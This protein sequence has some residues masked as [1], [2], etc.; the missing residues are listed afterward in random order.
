MQNNETQIAVLGGGSWGTALVKLLQYNNIKTGWWIRRPEQQH[1]ILTQHHNPD[2]LSHTE[3]SPELLFTTTDLNEL[4]WHNPLIILAI[5]SAYIDSVFSEIPVDVFSKSQ[6]ISAVKGIEPSTQ[7]PV[8]RWLMERFGMDPHQIGVIGGP[9]HSEEVVMQRRSY[10][11][12]GVSDP[13][14]GKTM[15]DLFTTPWVSVRI[16]EDVEGIGMAA[17]L[18][19]VYGIVAG[20]ATGLRYGDNFLAVLVTNMIHEMEQVLRDLTGNGRSIQASVYAGDLL[21][22]AY[23]RFSRNWMFGNL[24]GRGYPVP[25]ALLELQMVAEGYHAIMALG[26]AEWFPLKQYPLLRAAHR[27]IALHQHPETV[28]AELRNALV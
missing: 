12:V 27:I 9:C 7:L 1:R 20:M 23:S 2:Y 22:T 6:V 16:S 15:S 14:L 17:I 18:K 21:V 4:L 10:I 3:L 5:P 26:T 19:N 8:H 28:F 25:S 11:T 13:A 24:I